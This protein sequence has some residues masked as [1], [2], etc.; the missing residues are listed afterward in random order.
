MFIDGLPMNVVSYITLY[1]NV[2]V[3]L[4]E[5]NDSLLSNIHQPFD[6]VT[7]IDGNHSRMLNPDS[8]N[9]QMTTSSVIAPISATTESATTNVRRCG[10]CGRPGHT[11]ETCFQSGGKMEGCREEYLANHPTKAQAH[12]ASVE[13]VQEGENIHET[14]NESLLKQEFAAMSLNLTNDINFTSYSIKSPSAG[15]L[16]HIILSALPECFNTAL[17]SACTNH[18]IHDRTLLQMYDTNGAIPVKT[19]NCGFLTTLAIGDVKFCIVIKG[20]TVIWTL[21]NCLHAPDVPI[22][23]I[24]VSALQEHHMSITFSF[25]KTTIAFLTSHPQLSGLSFDAKVIHRL[26]LLHLD[27]ITSTTKPPAIVYVLFQVA[28]HSIELWHH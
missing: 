8:R 7:R 10:N 14:G 9:Q 26:S 6:H 5:P 13:E 20:Q 16:N 28:P 1:D 25:Q 19:A 12:F 4:N 18:I 11:D 24:S 3:L 2:M 22:N 23:L 17:D 15:S 27:Y 21:K